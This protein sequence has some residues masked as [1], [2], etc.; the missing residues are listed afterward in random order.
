MFYLDGL[1]LLTTIITGWGVFGFVGLVVVITPILKS[2]QHIT[3]SVSIESKNINMVCSFVYASNYPLERRN[4][5]VDLCYIRSSL[6]LPSTPWIVL[7]DF[8]EILSIEDHSRAT[9]YAINMAR[10]HDFQNAVAYCDIA[11]IPSAGPSYT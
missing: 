11:D 6:L 7:G 1:L 10:M 2:S 5:W 4:L 8:N 9:D 3:C